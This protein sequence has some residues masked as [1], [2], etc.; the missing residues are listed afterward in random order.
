[1]NVIEREDGIAMLVAMMA[2]LLMTAIGTA[3][4][5]SSTSETTIAAQFRNGIEAHYAA[6]AM[7][8]RGMDDLIDVADWSL[9]TGGVL[10]SSWADGPPAGPRTLA[11]GS[12]I[13]LTQIVNAASCEKSTAC[14][15]ADLA[16]ITPD[17]PWGAN[18]PQWR[19]YAYG[20]LRDM[21]PPGIIESPYYVVLLVANGPSAA[22][23]AVRA[24]AF[25]PRGAHAVSEITAGRA[26]VSEDEKDYNDRPGQG[27]VK[28]LSW[29]EVR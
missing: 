23:L 25:G 28:V 12:T 5:V 27:A 29:R 8:N 15:Q 21:L 1:V 26:A 6:D 4:I 20:R 10:P 14:S 16:D 3:L 11:D 7:L 24:E 19:L 17:R 9:V 13:D 2:M 22:L 18:N